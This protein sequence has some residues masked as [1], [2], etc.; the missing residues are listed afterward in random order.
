[1]VGTHGY[2]LGGD[3]EGRWSVSVIHFVRRDG[4]DEEGSAF[5]FAA[6]SMVEACCGIVKPIYDN[7]APPYRYSHQAAGPPVRPSL[8]ARGLSKVG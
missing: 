2:M 6:L 4:V 8:K 7:G 5:E 3:K 1:M